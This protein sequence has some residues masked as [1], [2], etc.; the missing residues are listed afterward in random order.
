[1][2]K[3]SLF[4]QSIPHAHIEDIPA[5]LEKVGSSKTRT[6]D[7]GKTGYETIKYTHIH[8]RRHY[9]WAGQNHRYRFH[10]L[11]VNRDDALLKH[12]R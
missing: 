6:L 4:G 3:K 9:S 1:M 12:E 2:S 10:V 11:A 5:P 7:D 8:S